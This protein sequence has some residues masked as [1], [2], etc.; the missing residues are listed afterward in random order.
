MRRGISP[1]KVLALIVVVIVALVL[2]MVLSRL[3]VGI[4]PA[5]L[6]RW[7]GMIFFVMF[8][9]LVGLGVFLVGKYVGRDK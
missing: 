3:I 2:C 5:A 1:V 8:I 9:V 7:F 6:N 4:N